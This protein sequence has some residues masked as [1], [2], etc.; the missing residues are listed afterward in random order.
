MKKR[1]GKERK[2]QL[3]FMSNS[4]TGCLGLDLNSDFC[5]QSALVVQGLL[6]EKK[7]LLWRVVLAELDRKYD[8]YNGHSIFAIKSLSS[9]ATG[10]Q[11][12]LVVFLSNG[13]QHGI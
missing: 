12:D 4:W 3:R 9:A 11:A 13:K 10:R 1:K 7:I 8:R 5:Y 2:I 6:F